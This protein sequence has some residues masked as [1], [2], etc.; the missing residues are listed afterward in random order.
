VLSQVSRRQYVYRLAEWNLSKYRTGNP[1]ASSSEDPINDESGDAQSAISLALNEGEAA[2]GPA[3]APAR[4]SKKAKKR[5]RTSSIHTSHEEVRDPS[6]STGPPG[7][8]RLKPHEEPNRVQTDESRLAGPIPEILLPPPTSQGDVVGHESIANTSSSDILA[9]LSELDD[10]VEEGGSNDHSSKG[11]SFSQGSACLAKYLQSRASHIRMTSSFP[12]TSISSDRTVDSFSP[13]ELQ[14]IELAANY[15]ECLGYSEDAFT[16]YAILLK[17]SVAESSQPW[18]GNR[19]YN[20]I[21]YSRCATKPEHRDIAIYLLQTELKKLQQEDSPSEVE[22]FLLKMMLAITHDG[23]V[24]S[25][26]I[27]VRTLLDPLLD[28]SDATR[29]VAALPDSDRSL[30]LPLFHSLLVNDF[31]WKTHHWNTKPPSV[32]EVSCKW[33]RADLLGDLITRRSPCASH[34]NNRCIRSCIEWVLVALNSTLDSDLEGRRDDGHWTTNLESYWRHGLRQM[35]KAEPDDGVVAEAES[36]ALFACL[37]TSWTDSRPFQSESSALDE[38]YDVTDNDERLLWMTQ[39]RRHMG[40]TI[41]KL[42]R[43]IAAL[44]RDAAPVVRTR[45]LKDLISQYRKGVAEL[46]SW[47]DE[48]LTRAF[49]QMWMSTHAEHRRGGQSSPKRQHLLHATK[50]LHVARLERVL[51]VKF[52]DLAVPGDAAPGKAADALALEPLSVALEPGSDRAPTLA[53]SFNSDDLSAFKR[54]AVDLKDAFSSDKELLY[55]SAALKSASRHSISMRT[56]SELSDRLFRTLSLHS[57]ANGSL[58]GSSGKSV[59]SHEDARSRSNK[60]GSS[61]ASLR[62]SEFSFH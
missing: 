16:L 8:K 33:S 22:Q 28:P 5:P 41:S 24:V 42:L 20:I 2:L 31:L 15:L 51:K 48:R 25:R 18:A 32:T 7:Q 10:T 12:P 52:D 39:T 59:L 45:E 37:W 21:A 58:Q 44:I 47:E 61:T 3:Q 30:D 35:Q 57:Q 46:R 4:V 6:N 34:L 19:R 1:A 29:L 23:D 53:P 17:R 26:I 49:I 27:E 11:A 43:V 56:V 54:A 55:P 60:A 38:N 50:T 40:I 62:I 14:K 9:I 13:E 36:E